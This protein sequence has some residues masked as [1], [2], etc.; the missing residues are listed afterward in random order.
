MTPLTGNARP[1]LA[2]LKLRTEPNAA[3]RRPGL[4][5]NGLVGMSPR[6]TRLEHHQPLSRIVLER[7]F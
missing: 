3:G 6:R 2:T 5:R 4:S 1:L 7:E